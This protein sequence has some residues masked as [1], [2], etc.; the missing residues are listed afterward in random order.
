MTGIQLR[1]AHLGTGPLTGGVSNAAPP[2]L[3][4]FPV[5]PSVNEAFKTVRGMRAKSKAHID[6][7]GH[8]R[9]VIR[10][11]KP[12]LTVGPVVLV[13]SVERTSAASDLDNRLKLIIDAL[14]DN[15]VIVD[16]RFVIG[17]CA[18]WAPPSARLARVMVMRAASLS[19][20]FQLA[21][22]ASA[23]G[24]FLQDAPQPEGQF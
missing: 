6:W 15:K 19:F 9:W 20:D 7:A 3:L 1:T 5:P 11:Q 12:T 2:V 22:D 8:A 14:V 23:G 16:D 4:T 13:I 18:A 17:L 10:Q 21:N 24:W